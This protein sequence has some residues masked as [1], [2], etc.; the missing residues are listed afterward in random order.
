MTIKYSWTQNDLVFRD[1]YRTKS[2]L[3]AATASHHGLLSSQRS[4]HHSLLD[5]FAAKWSW[6]FNVNI[7]DVWAHLLLLKHGKQLSHTI[8]IGI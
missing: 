3:F 6:A 2:F 4:N 7:P 8:Y 5:E 1:R